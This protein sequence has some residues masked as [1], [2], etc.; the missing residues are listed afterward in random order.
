MTLQNSGSKINR[1]ALF[2]SLYLGRSLLGHKFSHFVVTLFKS[3]LTREMEQKLHTQKLEYSVDVDSSTESEENEKYF[4][5][6]TLERTF[7]IDHTSIE[8]TI[9]EESESEKKAMKV[10]QTCVCSNFKE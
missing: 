9:E 10:F 3:H 1:E 6:E 4:L 2:F 8:E 7:S 5:E